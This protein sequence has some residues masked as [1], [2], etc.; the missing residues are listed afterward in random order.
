MQREIETLKETHKSIRVVQSS[1]ED[2]ETKY[3]KLLEENAFLEAELAIQKSL[4]IDNQRLKDELR[5]TYLELSLTK[6]KLEQVQAEKEEMASK[7]LLWHHAHRPPNTSVIQTLPTTNATL[8]QKKATNNDQ[9]S[10]PSMIPASITN[11]KHNQPYS[12]KVMR[13]MSK[14]VKNL[15]SRLHSCRMLVKPL[16]SRQIQYNSSLP[17]MAPKLNNH[18]DKT[19]ETAELSCHQPTSPSNLQY[20]QSSQ[21]N[22]STQNT[23]P[24]FNNPS[25]T[26]LYKSKVPVNK[27]TSKTSE[28]FSFKENRC[29]TF[30]DIKS[31]INMSF[32]RFS[33]KKMAFE[34][35][36][37]KSPKR[38][39]IP[40]T[41]LT[42]KEEH[43]KRMSGIPQKI[44]PIKLTQSLLRKKSSNIFETSSNYPQR[45]IIHM[46]SLINLS[47]YK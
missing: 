3:N 18:H 10:I 8:E 39:A 7:V 2:L 45:K 17:I 21:K 37:M 9:I 27:I 26:H 44:H 47:K 25:S 1:F 32:R 33:I 41:M 30:S 11:E 13:E 35:N 5:D 24:L 36:P 23:K 42:P 40:S 43:K 28:P 20:T 29:E 46:S 31:S 4:E 6:E 14:R 22:A 34:G 16:S 19:S 38:E 15:E 12:I